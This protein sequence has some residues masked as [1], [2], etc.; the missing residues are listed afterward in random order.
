MRERLRTWREIFGVEGH[1][2]GLLR[3]RSGVSRAG[4][5]MPAAD[6]FPPRPTDA[7]HRE[8]K[9]PASSILHGVP[10]LRFAA[11]AGPARPPPSSP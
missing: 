5:A 11:G 7:L 3:G 10:A 8:A 6:D 9:S 4:Q 1:T 2:H